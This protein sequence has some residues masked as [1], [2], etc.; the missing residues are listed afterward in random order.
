MPTLRDRVRE[1][2]SEGEPSAREAKSDLDAVLERSRG[3]RP[4]RSWGV[5]LPV[6]FAC[7]LGVW[8]LVRHPVLPPPPPVAGGIHVY[9]HVR[10]EPEDRALA[11]HLEARG[12]H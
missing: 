3:A 1:T 7:A 12:A 8:L 4:R 9:L 2:L 10:G 6:A 5:A 11:L